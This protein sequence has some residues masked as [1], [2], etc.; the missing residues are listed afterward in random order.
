MIEPSR[1][2][3]FLVALALQVCACGDDDGAN[4]STAS[5]TSGSTGST[6]STHSGSA[7]P[8]GGSTGTSSSSGTT[9]EPTGSTSGATGTATG[10]GPSYPP[11]DTL[12]FQP[13]PDVPCPGHR[14]VILDPTFGTQVT[15]VNDVA[16]QRH[17]YASKAAWNSDMSLLLL[18]YP[19][20]GSGSQ[21]AILDGSTYEVLQAN[22]D[23]LGNLTWSNTDPN[24]AFG[25]NGPEMRK[26]SV[27]AAGIVTE[28][29]TPLPAYDAITLGGGHGSISNNDRYLCFNWKIDATNTHGV[30]VFDTST[31]TVISEIDIA[32]SG[33]AVGAI[34]DN[35]GMS[36]S[37]EY[38]V[39]QNAAD[40][41]AV[42]EGCW[43]YARD[44][45]P[46]T[47]RHVSTNARHWDAG[48]NGS[49]EDVLVMASQSSGGGGGGDHLG[50]YVMATGAFTSLLTPW[51]DGHISTRNVLRPGWAYV[52]TFSTSGTF[53]GFGEVFAINLDTP[54]TVQRFAHTHHAVDLGYAGEPHASAS[55]DGAR[56]IWASEWTDSCDGSIYAYVAGM[57]VNP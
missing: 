52:S 11:D 15:R 8:S 1:P 42:E 23:T 14:E 4:T 2:F 16:G 43:I 34:V 39:V 53:A 54:S 12:D 33:A 40:G 22:N 50:S 28:E 17:R 31:N 3:P 20:G 38:V 24:A 30:G 6:G 57:N 47:R 7:G 27:S 45:S 10:S 56:V 21:R 55:P 35:C 26:L 13:T 36:Q 48:V 9:L 19:P 18:D 51:P 49:G 37:G 44:L 5:T 29:T 46:A 25:S 32:T 41:N